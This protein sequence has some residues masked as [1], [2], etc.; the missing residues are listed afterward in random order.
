MKT[1]ILQN[2]S[3]DEKKQFFSLDMAERMI[4]VE[5]S[6]SA[7]FHKYIPYNETEYY[8]CMSQ[9]QKEDFEKFIR[10]KNK[11]KIFSLAALLAPLIIILALKT[12]MTGN[13]ISEN[14]LPGNAILIFEWLMAALFL[15]ILL[16]IINSFISK[17]RR[18]RK[19]KP[20][21]KAMHDAASRKY[22][23]GKH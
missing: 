23:S 12:G 8:R 11:K 16:I 19:F 21:T 20:H 4:R 15:A 5:Q 14:A 9:K 22:H 2:M 7:S 13:A 18:D 6:I 3:S 10:R 1:K 17:K